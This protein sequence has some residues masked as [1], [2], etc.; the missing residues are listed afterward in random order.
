MEGVEDG[1]LWVGEG[2]GDFFEAV[3][4]AG[5]LVPEAAEGSEDVLGGGAGRS[6]FGEE[7]GD[8]AGGGDGVA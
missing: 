3:G 4:G 5:S 7:T 8:G 1:L 6:A 2:I